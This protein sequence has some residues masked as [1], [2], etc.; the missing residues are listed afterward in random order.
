[1]SPPLGPNRVS[2]A[3]GVLPL[4]TNE[5][6]SLSFGDNEAAAVPSFNGDGGGDM[7]MLQSEVDGGFVDELD[8]LMAAMEQNEPHHQL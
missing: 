1:M 3:T 7:G 4:P 5:A 2:V 8:E 6:V